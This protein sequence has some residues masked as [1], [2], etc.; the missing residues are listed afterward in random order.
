MSVAKRMGMFGLLGV[1]GIIVAFGG[2]ALARNNGLDFVSPIMQVLFIV[3]L[4]SVCAAL[5]TPL[6]SKVPS[7]IFVPLA[8]LAAVVSVICFYMMRQEANEPV[9]FSPWL[10]G[11][12]LLGLSLCAI[13]QR[14]STRTDN[15][16]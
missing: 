9:I 16:T 6:L 2:A 12:P 5:W 15:N 8:A 4:S 13:A 11:Y 10:L 1:I 14:F 3:A 7:R